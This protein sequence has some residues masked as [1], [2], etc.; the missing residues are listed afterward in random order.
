MQQ[1]SGTRVGTV[2]GIFA[3]DSSHPILMFFSALHRVA[4]IR[5][6]SNAKHLSG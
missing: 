5:D 1:P 4:P 6:T 3:I 2:K